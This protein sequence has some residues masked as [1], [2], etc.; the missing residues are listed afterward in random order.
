MKTVVSLLSFFVSVPNDDIALAEI[1][2]Y[3]TW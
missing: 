1:M 2:I 3:I